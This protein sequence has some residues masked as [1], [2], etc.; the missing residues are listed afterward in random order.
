MS[1]PSVMF[2]EN[3]ELKHFGMGNDKT[4]FSFGIFTVVLAVVSFYLFT[5]LDIIFKN[6]ISYSV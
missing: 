5:L 2:E 3:G 4:L 6:K 1:K